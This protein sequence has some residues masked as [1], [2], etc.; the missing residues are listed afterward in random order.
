MSEHL[1]IP[2]LRRDGVEVGVLGSA[3]A[4]CGQRQAGKD[5]REPEEQRR[6]QFERVTGYS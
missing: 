1:T 6:R 2:Q 4:G 5:R 3:A